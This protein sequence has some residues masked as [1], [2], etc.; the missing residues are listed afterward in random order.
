MKNY[1][2]CEYTYKHRR[3]FEY[4]AKKLIKNEESLANI[5]ERARW[6]DMDK[7]LMYQFLD[8]RLSQEHHVLIKPHHLEYKGERSYYDLLETVIDYECSPYTKPDKPLNAYDFLNKLL[9]MK[10]VDQDVADKLFEIM[11]ELGIDKSYSVI[12]DKEGMAYAQSLTGIT[13]KMILQEIDDYKKAGKDDVSG[14]IKEQ[15]SKFRPVYHLTPPIGWMNDPNGLCELNGVNHIFFQ[16]S[17]DSPLGADK[18]WG[19]YETKDFVNYKYTG[20]AI[21]PDIRADMNGVFSGSSFVEDGCMYIYYTGNVELAGDYD[22]INEGREGNTIL[23]TSKDGIDISKKQWLLKDSDYPSDISNHVRDPKVFK[24][25][26]LYLMVLGARSK[27]DEGKAL[28]YSSTDKINWKF[29]HYIYK[30]NMGYMWEC[31][32][33]FILDGHQYLS[34]SP[35]GLKKEKYKYQNIYQSG[36]FIA[37][38]NLFSK[39]PSLGEFYEWDYGFDFYAPQTYED[40]EGRRILIGWMGIPDEKYNYDPTIESGW[41]HML[42]LP[43]ELK[44][45]EDGRILQKPIKEIDNL[46][47]KILFEDKFIEKLCLDATPQYEMIIDD[48][49]SK[50]FY[51]SLSKGLKLSYKDNVIVL[52]FDEGPGYG[53]DKRLIK[54]KDNEKID[55][56][57]IYGDISCFEIYINDGLYVMSTKYYSESTLR[58]ISIKAK[59][60]VTIYELKPFNISYDADI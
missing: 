42:T 60:N 22:Y 34:L 51:I 4:I 5:L 45:S 18:Y 48:I 2:W 38:S 50:E 46:R 7:L 32:D 9:D 49:E 25:S 39:E 14:W 1:D 3:M 37:E 20:I 26:D 54:L 36:Y 29:E 53:R 58:N 57:H 31:P 12:D 30:E 10:L 33:I 19:H 24:F 44:R 59:A 35:Q 17:P 47:G 23:V 6:H 56:V 52:E 16:Y 43:R 13:A 55:N 41:Q 11:H 40:E 28:L 27:E 8:Q 15:L 21:S